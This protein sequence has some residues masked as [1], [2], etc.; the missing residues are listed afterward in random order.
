MLPNILQTL[1]EHIHAPENNPIPPTPP[2]SF[3]TPLFP[4][5][6]PPHI[7]LPKNDVVNNM[8][9]SPSVDIYTWLVRFQKQK[10]R[11]FSSAKFPVEAQNW[12]T[13]IEKIFE[14]MGVGDEFKARLATY[15]LEDDA[16][17]WWGT[18]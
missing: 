8:V 16:Q 1:N 17:S 18:I 6:L 4:P 9:M 5:S 14:V 11:S 10:P 15:K 12:I 7:S 2:W 3:T 13:H